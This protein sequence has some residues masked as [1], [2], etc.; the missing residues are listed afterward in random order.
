MWREWV[1]A[2]DWWA[3]GLELPV[4]WSCRRELNLPLYLLGGGLCDAMPL[5]APA[6]L[7]EL[8]E[9]SYLYRLTEPEEKQ[10]LALERDKTY[11]FGAQLGSS[12]GLL[13]ACLPPYQRYESSG[14]MLGH[15]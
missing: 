3:W 4:S 2:A 14:E 9:R 6:M 15:Q 12:A 1:G 10:P 7:R 5:F 13:G 11:I 8:R